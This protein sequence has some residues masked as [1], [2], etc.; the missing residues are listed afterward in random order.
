MTPSEEYFSPSFKRSEFACR[1]GC[2]QAPIDGALIV[3]LQAL[4]DALKRPIR[5][6]S[7]YR[8]PAHNA[9]IGGA[10]RSLHTQGKAADIQVVGMSARELYS[11]ALL[12][13]DFNGFGVDDERGFVHVDVR[14]KTAR[15]CYA[16]GRE[17]TWRDA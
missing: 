15:W 14:E 10:T 5:I 17:T 9:A 13:G 12:H 11:A 7:G 3:S 2:A 8:C 6:L 4:R 1:C 16:G